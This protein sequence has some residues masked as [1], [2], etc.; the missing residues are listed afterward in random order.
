[1]I[2]SHGADGDRFGFKIKTAAFELCKRCENVSTERALPLSNLHPPREYI[3]DCIRSRLTLARLALQFIKACYNKQRTA[4]WQRVLPCNQPIFRRL[5][6]LKSR[7][8]HRVWINFFQACLNFPMCSLVGGVR[9]SSGIPSY[10]KDS[11]EIHVCAFHIYT[12]K[13][14]SIEDA[15]DSEILFLFVVPESGR[16]GE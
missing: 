16:R 2:R 8:P 4:R 11:Q 10:A 13:Y 1:M 7:C 3:H 6:V 15:F 14:R 12:E 9:Y 5:N